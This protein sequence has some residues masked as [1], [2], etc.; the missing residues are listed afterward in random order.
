MQDFAYNFSFLIVKNSI[1]PILLNIKFNQNKI[2]C[3][4]L[5]PRA[6]VL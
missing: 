1:F 5:Q 3:T 2:S 6:S 4:I